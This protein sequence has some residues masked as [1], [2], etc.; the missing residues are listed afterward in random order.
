MF[1]EEQ[2]DIKYHVIKTIITYNIIATHHGPNAELHLSS[3]ILWTVHN[4][5]GR[6]IQYPQS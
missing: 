1:S 5:P 4:F 6:L 2:T 3:R